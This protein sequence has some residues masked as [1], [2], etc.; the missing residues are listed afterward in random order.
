MKCTRCNT[1][2]N[3]E[4]KYCTK[5]GNKLENDEICRMTF[6][7]TCGSENDKTARFCS[8]CGYNL[9]IMN[10]TPPRKVKS[11]QKSKKQN[12]ERP[13]VLHFSGIIKEHKII[14]GAVVI[15]LVFLI[16]QSV[17]Q[18]DEYNNQAYIPS[19]VN[20]SLVN[21]ISDSI[22]AAVIKNFDCACGECNDPLDVCTCETAAEERRFIQSEAA[23]DISAEGII[24][25]VKNKYGGL[26]ASTELNFGG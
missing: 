24:T 10:N 14:T 25:A 20:G 7:P 15:L 5:C 17:P 26:K 4:S 22:T 8:N 3:N 19:G 13:K 18:N 11:N 1:E 6:C 23:R 2:N 21:A 16:Y 9:K 12:R